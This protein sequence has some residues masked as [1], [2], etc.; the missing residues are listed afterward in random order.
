MT[1]RHFSVAEEAL[2]TYV[3]HLICPDPGL[4]WRKMLATPACKT[5]SVR[6]QIKQDK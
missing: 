5:I 1:F 6:R 4:E 2:Q 3:L